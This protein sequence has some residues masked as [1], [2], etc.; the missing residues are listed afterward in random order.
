M[1]T[2]WRR[3]TRYAVIDW[4]YRK[5]YITIDYRKVLF[6]YRNDGKD[7]KARKKISV[8]SLN[9]LKVSVKE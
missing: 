1:P 2:R 6:N 7:R 5:D 9:F 3:S 4:N 8:M